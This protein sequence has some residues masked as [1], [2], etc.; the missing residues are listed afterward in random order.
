M[1]NTVH[2]PIRS[3]TDI[4]LARS[5]GK[6]LAGRIGFGGMQGTLIAAV[7]SEVVRNILEYAKIGVVVLSECHK[8][9]LHGIQVVAMDEGPAIRD[10]DEDLA[11]GPRGST[12]VVRGRGLAVSRH[13]MD[14]FDLHSSERRGTVV[15]LRKW[16]SPAYRYTV[17]PRLIDWGVDSRSVVGRSRGIGT[18]V[19]SEFAKGALV[20]VVGGTGEGGEAALAESAVAVTLTSHAAEPIE[21]LLWLCHEAARKTAG[22]TVGLASFDQKNE[23]VTCACV[24]KVHGFFLRSNGGAEPNVE[25]MLS[26][27][28]TLGSKMPLLDPRVMPVSRGDSLAL[29]MDGDGVHFPA[30]LLRHSREMPQVMAERVLEQ[31]DQI[32]PEGALVLVAR[33]RGESF[34]P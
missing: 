31:D 3:E 16:L 17:A 30:V 20:G 9:I 11:K 8:G 25:S 22:A 1:K 32:G 28:G 24:G 21:S 6:A 26:R 29:T 5:E 23:T 15:I 2:V 12:A 19:V 27:E 34:R 10:L 13:S 4:L 7:I 14:E 33:Y 18:Y